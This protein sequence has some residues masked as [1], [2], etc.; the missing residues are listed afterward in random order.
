MPE[1][2]YRTWRHEDRDREERA[3]RDARFR[4]REAAKRVIGDAMLIGA[5]VM[6]AWS[7][8]PA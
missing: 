8:M 4:R 7:M 6:F 3:A 2:W 5:I 1:E